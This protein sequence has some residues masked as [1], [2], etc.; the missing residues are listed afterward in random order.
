[1]VELN[2]SS[3]MALAVALLK[4]GDV[5][6][7]AVLLTRLEAEKLLSGELGGLMLVSR[8]DPNNLSWALTP[9][10]PDFSESLKDI[11]IKLTNFHFSSVK[12]GN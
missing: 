9:L 6:G 4:I 10:L 12:K 3:M 7:L 5:M 8:D 2:T 11:I 1:M